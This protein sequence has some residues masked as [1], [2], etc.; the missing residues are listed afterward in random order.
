MGTRNRL[1]VQ[2]IIEGWVKP[3]AP[4]RVGKPEMRRLAHVAGVAALKKLG[5][6]PPQAIRRK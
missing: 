4:Q 1:R 5:L 2:A 6:A 3:I